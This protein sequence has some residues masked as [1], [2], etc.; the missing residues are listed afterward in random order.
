MNRGLAQDLELI[1]RQHQAR[2]RAALGLLLAGGASLLSGRAFAAD[3]TP[4][5]RETPGPFPANGSN[6]VRG[7]RVNVLQ[8]SGIVRSDIRS[9]FGGS[10]AAA[11][12]VP[13]ALTVKLQNSRRACAALAG[14]AI[15]VWQADRNG[16]YSLYQGA[17][18]SENY[19]R[20]VQIADASGEATFVTIFPPCY[21]GRYPHI[22]FEVYTGRDVRSLVLTSQIAM[23][24][25]H[26]AAVYRQ[27]AGYLSSRENFARMSVG[28]DGVFRDNTAAQIAAMTPQ[29]SGDPERGFTGELTVAV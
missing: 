26:S 28:T 19:L 16:E 3:C 17:A 11:P 29:L 18:L 12:G 6:N 22:H 8:R 5:A 15:Y 27:A 23:P 9:S 25:D 21:G 20:G 13:L 4:T 2:R 7:A 14:H 24:A 1:D 10:A